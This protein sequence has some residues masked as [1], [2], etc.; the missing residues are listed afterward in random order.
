MKMKEEIELRESDMQINQIS[1]KVGFEDPLYFSRMFSKTMKLS[2]K[3]YRKNLQS[4]TRTGSAN[5]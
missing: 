2:P 4:S 5:T 1:Y 3:E